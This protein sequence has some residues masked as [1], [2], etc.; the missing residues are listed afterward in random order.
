[1]AIRGTEKRRSSLVFLFIVS[2]VF[3]A[4]TAALF[5]AESLAAGRYVK[6]SAE[7]VVRTG[8]GREYK[9]I[10]MVKD[11]DAVELLE[12]GDSYSKVRLANGIE[13]WMLKRFLSVK[14]PLATVVAALRAEN[15]KMKREATE[16]T[17]KF[18]EVSE[19]LKKT[20]AELDK[21]R[22]ERDQVDSDYKNLQVETADVI[23]IKEDMLRASQENEELVQQMST[24]KKENDDLKNNTSINWF[25]AGGGVLLVGM[26]L[27]R[28]SSKSRKRRSSLL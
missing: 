22:I 26:F 20:L 21:T 14:P 2:F 18:E 6:P 28:L 11:G 7:V 13:G 15:D 8:G 5:V 16:M 24:L 12:E 25:L 23:K 10:G 27:G 19:N 1:M 3:L 4:G 17:G 9:V